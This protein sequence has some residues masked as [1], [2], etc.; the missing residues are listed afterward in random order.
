[1]DDTTSAVIMALDNDLVQITAMG[2][3]YFVTRREFERLEA[4]SRMIDE[5]VYRDAKL[6]EIRHVFDEA[7]GVEVQT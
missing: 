5:M 4:H 6:S 1:M 7:S 2:R 3:L